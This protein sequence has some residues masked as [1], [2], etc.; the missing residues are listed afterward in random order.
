MF[1]AASPR[2]TYTPPEWAGTHRRAFPPPL[3]AE[4]ARG[5]WLSGRGLAVPNPCL[6]HAS[7]LRFQGLQRG[8]TH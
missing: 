1:F 5:D 6:G 2:K 3:Q 7:R 4:L 8:E